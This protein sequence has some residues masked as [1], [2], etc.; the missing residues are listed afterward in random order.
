MH[1][2]IQLEHIKQRKEQLNGY[3]QNNRVQK[4]DKYKL[5]KDLNIYIIIKK[6][7]NKISKI[8]KIK[9]ISSI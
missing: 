7:A 8:T 4:I 1:N 6:C 2:L 9:I 3:Y 5:L